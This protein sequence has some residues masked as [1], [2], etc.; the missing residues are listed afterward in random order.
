MPLLS[1]NTR[2]EIPPHQC[3]GD[4]MALDGSGCVQMSGRRFPKLLIND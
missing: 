1:V 3:L 4:G 2:P